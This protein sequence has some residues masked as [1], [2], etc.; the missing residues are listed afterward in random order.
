MINPLRH[1]HR[2]PFLDRKYTENRREISAPAKIIVNPRYWFL[3]SA[4][5]TPPPTKDKSSATILLILLLEEKN[6]PLTSTGTISAIILFQGALPSAS[7]AVN[8]EINAI[9]HHT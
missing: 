9:S 6:L 1:E 3:V 4:C 5:N 2:V 8:T 7:K